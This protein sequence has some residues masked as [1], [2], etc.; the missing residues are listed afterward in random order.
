MGRLRNIQITKVLS[1]LTSLVLNIGI[2]VLI[3]TALLL[4]VSGSRG[5]NSKSLLGFKAYIVLSGSMSP[6]FEAGSMILVKKV[7][8]DS[9]K[10]G[11]ILTYKP[12][13]E[14]NVLLTHRIIAV[15]N[16][17]GAEPTFKTQGD[18]NNT[19]DQGIVTEAEMMGKVILHINN[20]GMF[21]LFLQT[22]LGMG[23]IVIAIIL[24]IGLPYAAKMIK[25]HE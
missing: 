16:E 13:P 24:R 25:Q 11:D 23:L 1:K 3:F 20:L 18:A 6:T 19:A 17:Q 9:L 14:S 5:G 22:P 2:A 10:V 15:N 7:P 8:A 12:S 4:A 21:F